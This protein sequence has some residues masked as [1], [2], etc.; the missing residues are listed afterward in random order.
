MSKKLQE[1]TS[2]LIDYLS[3]LTISEFDLLYRICGQKLFTCN[4]NNAIDLH[5]ERFYESKGDWVVDFT[6]STF[7]MEMYKYK[8]QDLNIEDQIELI[9]VIE[10]II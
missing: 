8:V 2:T 3:E 6:D 1:C 4:E 7:G 5:L 9:K 10:E